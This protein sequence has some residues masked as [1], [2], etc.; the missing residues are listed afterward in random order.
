MA[1]SYDD[2]K[3]LK[4]ILLQK[5]KQKRSIVKNFAKIERQRLGLDRQDWSEESGGQWKQESDDF[6][7]LY[8][9][10]NE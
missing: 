9:I 6:D 5:A 10:E 3:K 1:K 2:Y 8:G 7:L 4:F